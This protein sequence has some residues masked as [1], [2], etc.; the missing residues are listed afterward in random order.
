MPAELPAWVYDVVMALQKWAEE[1]PR[2]LAEFYPD[3]TP[4]PVDECGCKAL[5]LVPAEV[6]AQATAVAA[7]VRVVQER[8]E[9]ALRAAGMDEETIAL[10]MSGPSSAEA[11]RPQR[12]SGGPVTGRHLVGE[13]APEPLAS[14][15]AGLK[16]LGYARAHALVGTDTRVRIWL[17]HNGGVADEGVVIGYQ[18]RPTVI[19][20]RDDGSQGSWSV[21][22]DCEVLAGPEPGSVNG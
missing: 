15:P 22:L 16:P 1:H 21:D 14:R 6:K 12:A 7:Y 19:V 8:A 20:K 10:V 3:Y 18:D 5:E 13:G 17:N 11:M 2:L 4:R 9:T